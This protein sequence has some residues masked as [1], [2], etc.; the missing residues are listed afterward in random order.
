MDR[1]K[2][3]RWS[4]N[5]EEKI[6]VRAIVYRLVSKWYL[7]VLFGV[8]G[9]GAGYLLT[10]Y[11]V[12]G[13]RVKATLFVPRLST[14]I[15]AGFE[16]LLPGD[17]I[18]NQSE[19]YN[20]MEILKSFY[21]HELVAQ[22]LNWRTSWQRKYTSEM[23]N[24]LRGRDFF[25]WVSYYKD[26]P[27]RVDE[28][29]GAAN[30]EGIRLTVEVVSKEQYKVT[31]S[32]KTSKDGVTREV[33]MNE[34]GTFGQPLHTEYFN[35]TLRPTGEK[36]IVKDCLYAF[37][38]NNLSQIAGS[39]RSRLSVGLNDK[40]SDIIQLGLSGSHPLREMDYL[41]ELIAVYRN[42][43]VHYQT[44]TYEQSLVFINRQL[45]GI[46]DS[47]AAASASFTR[48][49]SQNQVI[50]I[51]K[52]GSQVMKALH[53][54][55]TD[56]TRNKLQLDY[57]G[58][59]AQYLEQSDG[60]NQPISPSV[61]GIQDLV[62]NKLVV[63][64]GE[65]LSRRQIL[66]FSART[67]NP[68]MQLIDKKI[69]QVNAN[70]KENLGNLIVNSRELQHSLEKNY[71]EMIAQ[72]NKL[73]GK[74]QQLI[75]FQRRYTVTNET[76]TYLLHRKAE[77][78]IA[79]AGA[80]SDVRVI[81]PA[82]RETTYLT[83]LSPRYMLMMGLFSGLA[84][85]GV[86]ILGMF[87][88][89]N[90]ITRQEDIDDHTQLPV[91]GHVI[92]NRIP[93]DT[94]VLDH[95]HSGIAEVYRN[96]RTN[97]QFMLPDKSR[98][99]V[100]IHSMHPGEGKSFTSVNLATILAMNSKRVLL[101]GCDMRR[102]RLHRIFT[103][104]NEHG[105][106]TLLSGQDELEDILVHTE[107]QHLDLIP[108][109]P[110]P[111]NPTELMEHPRMAQLM[112]DM[113]SRYDYVLLDN[114]PVSYV[115]DGFIAG[116]FAHLNIFILRYGVS[117]KEQVHHINQIAANSQLRHIGLIVNDIIGTDFGMGV[118]YQNNY[119][120]RYYDQGYYD[121]PQEPVKGIR[122]MFSRG[123]VAM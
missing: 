34:Q 18:E 19:V 39:Y 72:L 87:F 70:L 36:P 37:Q 105:L 45:A 94:P 66:M 92:H 25:H 119:K 80:T 24:L 22:H 11:T 95:P 62:F 74:E 110:L 111:P 96:I 15:E 99:I 52:Q 56:K 89:S 3:V 35:F 26:E 6:D 93:S 78:D 8:M 27:F 32:F 114:A 69:A 108:S 28:P 76:Y 12:S 53:E 86:W 38:F 82:L 61:V 16:G 77:M 81:D 42:N 73:P 64:L 2:G 67:D 40:E 100:A 7:F 31:A 55:E 60:L 71:G 13:Y 57:F 20:Q 113:S 109:G 29:K 117:K 21:L 112:K 51:S 41:N 23:E 33:E 85:P 115:S 118:K 97:L 50:N 5:Q 106:S 1:T 104:S 65:L 9:L 30:P 58:N 17:L 68:T 10:R 59:L 84:I 90:I 54:L 98:N 122:R 47:L 14:G 63:E 103:C 116:K 120:G 4:V 91:M 46:S 102:P 79:L 123:K 88:L 121:D 75:N 49:R 83:G 43:K 44:V 48:F 107:V 101:I